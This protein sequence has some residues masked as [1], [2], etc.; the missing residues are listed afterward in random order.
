MNSMKSDGSGRTFRARAAF[1]LV[2]LVV[3]ALG[4]GAQ[5]PH[6]D[7]AGVQSSAPGSARDEAVRE[8]YGNL[9]ISIE[10]NAGQTDPSVRYMAHM[11]GGALYFTP[12]EVVLA[13]QGSH[14]A[15]DGPEG[16]SKPG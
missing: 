4:G 11:P 2:P 12:S 3:L 7:P 9:P 13:L 6:G 1:V 10:A 15:H 14:T 16:S 5:E 8:A